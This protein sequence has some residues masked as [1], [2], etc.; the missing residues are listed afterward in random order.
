MVVTQAVA[1]LLGLLSSDLAQP[2][3]WVAWLF[4]AY[5]SEVVRLVARLP[6]ASIDTGPVAPVLVWA[7]YGVFVLWFGRDVLRQT[8]GLVLSGISR[9]IGPLQLLQKTGA[10]WVIGP[11]VA[12]AALLWIAAFSLP[13]SRLHVTFVDV[14]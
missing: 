4:T 3:G 5:I 11:V 12:V 6:G 13:G 9:T 10:W 2:F 7:Y 8:G 14:G 1:G